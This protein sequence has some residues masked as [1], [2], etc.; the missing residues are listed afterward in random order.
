MLKLIE[1]AA[2]IALPTEYASDRRGFFIGAV[3]IR[4]DGALVSAKNGA[5]EFEG[6]VENYQLIPNAHAEPRVIRKMGKRGTLYVARV[7]KGTKSLAM[8][9]PCIICLPFL[10]A[11]QVQKCYYS[12]NDYQYGILD[13][14]KEFDRVIFCKE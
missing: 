5:V 8:S 7:L 13:V 6:T 12:I 14:E 10:R 2:K 11:F 1:M 3:G 9:R 4:E